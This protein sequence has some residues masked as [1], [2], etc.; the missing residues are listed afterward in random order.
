MKTYQLAPNVGLIDPAPPIPGFDNFITSYV[1][2]DKQTALIDIGPKSSI[3]NIVPG[4][5]QLNID[6][7]EVSYILLTHIHLDHAGGVGTLLKKMP[8]AQV[9][10]HE[11][12]APHLIDPT[13][14]W[15][16]SQRVLGQRAQEYGDME[17]VAPDKIIV[18]QEGMLLHI[19][20]TEL[21]V[22][23]TPGHAPHHMSFFDRNEGRLFLGEMG[24]VYLEEAD[25]IRPACPSPF[26]LEQKLDSLN[27][28]I[29]LKPKS[30]CY[31]HFGQA[32]EHVID[33]LQFYR[34]QLILWGKTIA[35]FDGK[36]VS[37]KE[38]YDTLRSKDKILERLDRLPPDRRDRELYFMDN[39]I[40]GFLGYFK[41]FGTEYISQL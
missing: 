4:L 15:E 8:N 39:D 33:K 30:L 36:E 13:R 29:N 18:G 40:S 34:Q 2:H 5:S 41:R 16:D 23:E 14:L 24:G 32:T 27:R 10:V 22:L 28:L 6:P 25:L 20:N 31:G 38:I 37:R 3:A 19:G 35:T 26:N 9:V 12:G 1:L 21:E 11:R 7:D 17:P